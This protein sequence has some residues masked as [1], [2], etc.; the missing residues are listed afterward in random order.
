MFLVLD[1]D[2]ISTVVLVD[3]VVRGG[4]LVE[5]RVVLVGAASSVVSGAGSSGQMPQCLQA[6]LVVMERMW[7]SA[8]AP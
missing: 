6:L 8:S 4:Y 1:H 2:V 5:V 3:K 7:F